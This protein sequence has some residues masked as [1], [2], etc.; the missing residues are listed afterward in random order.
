MDFNLF[1]YCTVGRRAE[2]EAGLA[3]RRTDLYQRMIDEIAEYAAAADEWGYAGFGHP[4]HHLQIEGF[5]ASNELGPMAMWLG[6][7]TK[8]M[9]VISCGWVSTTHN[10]LR[11]AEYIATLDNML[12]GRFS[13]GLVRGYQARWV[14]NF[15]VRPELRAVGPWNKDTPD[16]DLNREYFAEYVDVVLKALRSETFSHRGRFWQFPPEGFSNPHRH[17]V[18]TRNGDGVRDDMTL[19]EVGIAPRPFQQPMPQLYGG[20]SA[21]LR[22]ALFWARHGGRPI[23][24]SDNLAFCKM[25]WSK[26]KEEAARHGH[27]IAEG[28]QAGW[29]GIMVCAPTDAQAQEWAQDMLWFWENWALPF[30]QGVPKLLVG[31]PDT[32]TRQ[33][34]EANEQFTVNDWFGLI[35]Q[36]LHEPSQVLTSLELFATKVMPR[37]A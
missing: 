32:I 14:E 29:G 30:G 17:D 2:L 21:S 6:S 22:T 27:D 35:P 1:M 5:E 4:E 3:G 36:G 8:R 13:F 31:S 9:K 28:D 34:E 37:F 18:Y 20:F 16:D 11:A 12:K 33:I 25:L 19:D 10:P 23:V 15:K 7:H 26:Y 24:L